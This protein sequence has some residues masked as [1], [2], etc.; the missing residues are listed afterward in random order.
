MKNFILISFISL[1]AFAS[2]T[3]KYE[4][5]TTTVIFHKEDSFIVNRSCL[6]KCQAYKQALKHKDQQVSPQDRVGGKNPSSVKC[7]KYLGGDVVF[8]SDDGGNQ[9]SFCL[10]TDKSYLLNQ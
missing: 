4:I 2:E 8:G 10:F 1:S 5:G 3:F 7:T 9:Q 6:Q